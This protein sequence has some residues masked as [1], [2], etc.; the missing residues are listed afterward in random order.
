MDIEAPK[1]QTVGVPD[2]DSGTAQSVPGR[3]AEARGQAEKALCDV[4][5]KT[6]HAMGQT[7]EKAKNYT[8]NKPDKA[9]LIALGIGVGLGFLLSAKSRPSRIGR[10]A[11][12]VVNALSE[13]AMEFLR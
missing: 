3:G 9:I 2:N 13:I 12:P 8:K 11:R 5:D 1:P 10:F 6:A 4:Y 7:Y